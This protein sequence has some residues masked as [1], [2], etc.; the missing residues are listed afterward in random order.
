MP[1]DWGEQISVGGNATRIRTACAQSDRKI[2][3]STGLVFTQRHTAFNKVKVKL[4]RGTI[5]PSR[6]CLNVIHI[7]DDNSQL[8]YLAMPAHTEPNCCYINRPTCWLPNRHT[9]GIILYYIL[10]CCRLFSLF[11]HLA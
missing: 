11:S 8:I 4:Y 2:C 1:T 7:Q 3:I 5:G 9:R 6:L 10:C